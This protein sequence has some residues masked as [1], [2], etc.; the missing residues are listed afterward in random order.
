MHGKKLQ[1]LVSCP[2]VENMIGLCVNTTHS[3]TVTADFTWQFP[4]NNFRPAVTSKRQTN[5][6]EL[7]YCSYLFSLYFVLDSSYII[8]QFQSIPALTL[9]VFRGILCNF[10]GTLAHRPSVQSL[11]HP[12]LGWCHRTQCDYTLPTEVCL[13]CVLP[14]NSRLICPH[15]TIAP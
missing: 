12:N 11:L 5:V 1:N 2:S 14:P 13:N 4:L 15:L 8:K 10:C 9:S 7:L 6:Y 3:C